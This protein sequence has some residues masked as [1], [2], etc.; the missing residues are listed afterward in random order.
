M[1][2]KNVEVRYVRAHPDR[3]DK[4]LV[5]TGAWSLQIFTRDKAQAKEWKDNNIKVKMNEDAEGIYYTS[6]LSK[7]CIKADGVTKADPIEIV[8]G[9]LVALDPGS[10]GNGTICNIRTYQYEVTFEGIKHIKTLPQALQI[11]KHVVY[12]NTAGPREEFERAE[13]ETVEPAEMPDASE[14]DFA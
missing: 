11:I 4:S 13:T 1:I 2:L 14:D 6:S 5:K 9:D 3:P 12:K 7:N 10:I 8:N